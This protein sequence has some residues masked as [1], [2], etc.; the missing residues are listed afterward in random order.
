MLASIG[1]LLLLSGVSIFL[2]G[3]VRRVFPSSEK[4]IPDDFK[5]FFTMPAGVYTFLAG[6]VLVRFF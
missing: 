1:V 2:F 5:A 3:L 6:L 4:F